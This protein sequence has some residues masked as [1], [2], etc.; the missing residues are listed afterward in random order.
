MPKSN[1]GKGSVQEKTLFN[2]MKKLA[3]VTNQR[4][5]RIERLTGIVDGFQTSQLMS[6]LSVEPLQAVTKK[7]RVSVKKTYSRTQ[8]TAIIHALEN[9]TKNELSTQKGVKSYVKELS[10]K[11]GEPLTF[12]QANIY[13]QAQ[14]HFKWIIDYFPSS[15]WDLARES[16]KEGW[17]QEKFSDVVGKMLKSEVDE[18]LKK[19]L[20]D[21]YN[22]T[23]DTKI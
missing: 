10:E 18:D 12:N 17:E 7:G 5:L 23:R 16:V 22:Y 20:K 3:K 9:F 13:Y 2:Q 6:L 19:D 21:L 14:G 11:A 4:I 8:L 15:F 1:K